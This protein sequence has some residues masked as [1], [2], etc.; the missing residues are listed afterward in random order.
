MRSSANNQAWS[1]FIDT[2]GL[3]VG[4]GTTKASS[5]AIVLVSNLGVIGAGL[6]LAFLG[7]VLRAPGAESS[8]VVRAARA[9]VLAA[10]IAACT[11]GTVFDLGVAFFAFAAAATVEER[12]ILSRVS[13]MASVAALTVSCSPALVPS[14]VPAPEG[15][16]MATTSRASA[17]ASGVAAASA[18]RP[19]ARERTDAVSFGDTI[20]LNVQFALG[21]PE[22]DVT[23]LADLGVRWVRDGVMWHELEPSPGAFRL[24]PGAFARRLEY[25]KAHDIGVVFLL[26]YENKVAYPQTPR[27]PLRPIDPVAFGRYA[28]EV[29]RQ[30][31]VTGVRFVLEIWNEPS[32]FTVRKLAGGAWNGT[33]P[34]PWVDA[35]VRI[36]N[37]TVAAVKSVD[38]A[39]T[40][41][42][43]DDMW[44][45]HYRFLQV[46]L[47]PRLDGFA[48]H[49]Y[50]HFGPERAAVGPDSEW[51]KPFQI[52]DQDSS[53]ESAVVR[54]RD[55]GAK[56][57]AVPPQMWITEWG[58]KLGDEGP[59][60]PIAEDTVVAFLP[61]AYVMA[62]NA[63]VRATLWFALRDWVDGPWGL[64]T[65][66]GRK[67]SSYFA[68]QALT[69]QLG[70][71]RLV[72]QVIGADHKAAGH[73]AFLFCAVPQTDCKLVV[74]TIDLA[75]VRLRLVGPLAAA[76]VVDAL[77]SELRP[78]IDSDGSHSVPIGQAPVYV[79]PVPTQGVEWSSFIS[80][81]GT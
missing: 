41:L 16:E 9:A 11:S 22:S 59:A 44:L 60:G 78:S 14:S 55:A 7:N 52:V 28:S 23:M 81:R 5:F 15:S 19:R 17:S 2:Y 45:L 32:N 35:Y 47:S 68:F 80:P 46:G 12:D 20:G 75:P 50:N 66:E 72:R 30:L 64:I 33:P 48:F 36:V 43:D 69:R 6:F 39:I 51:A 29:A 8:A 53:F 63:R 67:R 40:V 26:A 57:L 3:G 73:Q 1:N 31:R 65:K 24:F 49:P 34:S 61:R 27:D 10:L 62:S 71:L 18:D 56:H 37:E 54:L 74:W 25:Y 21:E 42:D 79:S 76:V 38:P 13:S 77:G 70:E 58:W 4:L